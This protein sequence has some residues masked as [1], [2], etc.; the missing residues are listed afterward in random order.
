MYKDWHKHMIADNCDDSR[1]IISPIGKGPKGDSVS[2][3]LTD[4]EAGNDTRITGWEY[5]EDNARWTELWTSENINGG[6]LTC[7]VIYYETEPPTFQLKFVYSRPGRD[8]WEV[9]TP[10]I[11]YSGE[12]PQPGTENVNFTDM[13]KIS[14]LP[15]D[16]LHQIVTGVPNLIV[17]PYITDLK[18][19]NIK[20]YIDKITNYLLTHV[21]LEYATNEE[22]DELFE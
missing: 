21:D 3:E 19:N 12:P 17:S 15:E 5:D 8:G 10:Q 14:G 4:S 20:D 18:G 9:T 22:V 1:P 13:S 2:I 6:K 7:D 11:Q 16:T